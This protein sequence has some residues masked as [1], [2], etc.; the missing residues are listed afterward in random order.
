MPRLVYA[1]RAR[2]R[3]AGTVTVF[4]TSSILGLALLLAVAS[5]CRRNPSGHPAAKSSAPAVSAPVPPAS[6][7][8]AS[9]SAAPTAAPAPDPKRYA[10]LADKSLQVPPAVDTLLSRFKT[11][12]GYARVKEAPG[13]FSAWLRTLPLAAPGTPVKNYKGDVVYPVGEKYV[14]AVVAIDVG[15]TDL[16]QSP[17][18]VVRLDAE[19]RWSNGDRKMSYLGKTGLDMP[20]WRYAKGQRIMTLDG[21][22]FWAPGANPARTDHALFREYLDAVFEWTDNTSLSKQGTKVAPAD[23]RPGDFFVQPGKPGDAVLV[24]D[25]A[26]K[27]SGRK[28]VLLGQ[29]LDPAE[30]MHVLRPGIGT[31]WFS[32]DPGQPL[33]TPHTAVFP[34]DGLRRMEHVDKAVPGKK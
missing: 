16:Q 17:D 11:P 31:A 19:W 14:A 23:I 4:R 10:W 25:I 6:Q 9:A 28:L 8:S 12:P 33:L 18:V 20:L 30:N 2:A 22:V 5:G 32:L 7:A 15:K 3:R 1:G 27:P 29:A 26:Q 34:W 13:S 24:L 21:N